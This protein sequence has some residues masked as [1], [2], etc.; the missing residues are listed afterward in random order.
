MNNVPGTQGYE[1]VVEAFIEASQALDFRVTNRDFL[2]FLPSVASRVLDA[3][4]G[5]GQNSAALARL[6]H[7]VTAVE[8]MSAFLNAAR[9]TY[10]G[11]DVEWIDDCL[12]LLAK[13]GEQPARFDFI[14][15]EAVWH[16]LDEDERVQAMERVANLLADE[17]VCAISLRHGP[18]GAGKHVHPTD[19]RRTAALAGQ[20]GLS[21]LMQV[22]GRPSI[23][24]NKPDVTWTRVAFMKQRGASR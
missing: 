9:S 3:G 15:I 12:P 17:G 10:A 5:A 7:T 24:K 22:S 4:A 2:E 13:L 16:H 6:G 8:P 1:K 19:G 11:L 20:C 18:A 23:M 14:L 21:L